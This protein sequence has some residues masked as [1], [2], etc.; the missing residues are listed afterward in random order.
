MARDQAED[1]MSRK[2]KLTRETI[3]LLAVQALD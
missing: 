2:L 1:S 3:R